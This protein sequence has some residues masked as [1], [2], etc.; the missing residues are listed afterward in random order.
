MVTKKHVKP[1]KS[2]KMTTNKRFKIER[3]VRKNKKKIR[4][5]I[6]K[7]AKAGKLRKRDLNPLKECLRIPNLYP[8][9]KQLIEQMTRKKNKERIAKKLKEKVKNTSNPENVEILQ[10]ALMKADEQPQQGGVHEYDVN[11]TY[12]ESFNQTQT[13]GLDIET[14]NTLGFQSDEIKNDVER[15]KAKLERNPKTKTFNRL[16]KKIFETADILLEVLD[17]RD[18][19]GCRA[20]QLEREFIS[21]YP[22]KKLILILNKIDLVPLEVVNKWKKILSNEFPTIPFKANLQHQRSNL[23]SGKVFSKSFETRKELVKEITQS[24]KAVGTDKLLELLKNYSRYE[25]TNMKSAITVGVIGMPNV[26]KSSLINSLLRRKAAGVSS[27]PGHTRVLKEVEL[28]SKVTIID[29]PGV[30]TGNEDETTLL[31]RNVIKAE[32]VQDLQKAVQVIIQ[33]IDK[34]FLLRFYRVADFYNFKEFLVNVGKAKGKFKKGGVV[35]LNL[36]ARMI[37]QD[38]NAGKLNYYVHPPQ[39]QMPLQPARIVRIEQPQGEKLQIE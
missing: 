32:D 24:T 19:Q 34:E 37:V 20:L 12:D 27:K 30:I 21:K 16:I 28:D 4:R 14:P 33:R 3:K 26:G 22:E 8:F 9:K 13:S 5:Q 11:V 10:N 39:G 31:L 25:G 36:T 18:P 7:M 35:D 2:K 23:S 1:N 6:K 17:A 38:W 29:C 15:Y